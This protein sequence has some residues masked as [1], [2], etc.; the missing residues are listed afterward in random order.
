[1]K[2]ASTLGLLLALLAPQAAPSKPNV[3]MIAIDDLRDWVRFLG[4]EQVRT[5]NLDRLAGRGTRFTRSYCAAPV[6]NPS[7]TALMSG[8]LPSTSGVYDNGTD[9]RKSI[10]DVVTLPQHLRANGYFAAGC[11]KIYH[12]A[13]KRDADWDE[14]LRNEG[15]DPKPKGGNDGVGGIKF[16]P[17]DCK[18]EDLRDYRIVSYA[19]SAASTTS[20]SSSPAASTSPTCRGTCRRSTS[21]YI[22]WIRSSSPRSRRRTSTTSPPPGSRWPNRPATTPTS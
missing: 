22:R 6:C 2:I 20:R 18:D 10:P 21:T 17:L 16:A 3:L 12:E 5:P 19:I 15:G 1:M 13:Y 14:Y 8:L 4:Y 11:G 9:W 7:R